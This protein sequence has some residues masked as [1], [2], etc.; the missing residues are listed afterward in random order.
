MVV[1]IPFGISD[2]C[3]EAQASGRAPTSVREVQARLAELKFLPLSGVD[4]KLG[5]RTKDAIT[6]FQQWHGLVPDGIAGPKTLGQLRSA[7]PPRPRANGPARRLEI[8]RAKGIT[9]VVENARVKRAIHSSAGKRGYETPTGCP[10]CLSNTAKTV[11]T[12]A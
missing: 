1:G 8:H 12:T 7:A 5:P 6:T 3:T 9:L 10:V 4:G 11:G 2:W